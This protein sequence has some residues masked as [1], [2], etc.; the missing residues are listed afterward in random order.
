MFIIKDSAP[1]IVFLMVDAT[2]DETAETGLSP[3]VQISKNGASFVTSSNSATEIGNGWYKLVLTTTESNTEG[4]L[5]VRA[6]GSGANEWRD[7]FQ[8]VESLPADVISVDGNAAT[9]L[10]DFHATGFSTHDELDSADAVWDEIRTGHTTTNSFG[11]WIQALALE[12]TI[13][14]LQDPSVATIADGVLD[15]L[16]A[17]HLTPGSVGKA[18][19][20]MSSTVDV[21][22][23]ATAVWEYA[24]RVLTTTFASVETAYA[25]GVIPLRRGDS[26]T[27]DINGIGDISSRTKL[28]VTIKADLDDIDDNAVLQWEE[29]TGLVRIN[30]EVGTGGN[31]AITVNSAPDG[32]LTVTLQ[33]A[34]AATLAP[35]VGLFMD[36]QW[37]DGTDILTPVEG[38]VNIIGDVTR[39][40]S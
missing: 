40:V 8:V 34:E 14:A 5:I 33:E 15:E 26:I 23:V 27:F 28:W 32:D 37:F 9:A 1:T 39:A 7:I 35:A 2:D 38:L 6:T 16:I 12:A 17:G 21:N 30:G 25:N 24:R 31:G 18:I 13:N 29:T 3:T 22:A 19:D 10:S 20:D 11:E 36:V 4:F